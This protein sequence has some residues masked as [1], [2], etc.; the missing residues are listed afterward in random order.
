MV[1]A[2][3]NATSQEAFGEEH[4]GYS[5]GVLLCTRVGHSEA[6]LLAPVCLQLLGSQPQS[7]TLITPGQKMAVPHLHKRESMPNET[8]RIGIATRRQA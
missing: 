8:N 7:A 6:S 2:G 4:L 1:G 5:S 3:G